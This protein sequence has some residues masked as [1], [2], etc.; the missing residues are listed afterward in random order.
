MSGRTP[1]SAARGR[2]EQAQGRGPGLAM[3]VNGASPPLPR[4]A[5]F[6]F[7]AVLVLWLAAVAWY[8]H[9]Q[10]PVSQNGGLGWDGAK[11]EHMYRQAQA[12]ERL[13]EEKPYVFRVATPWLAAHLGMHEARTAFHIVNLVSVLITGCLMLWIMAALGAR[14]G[15][16]LFL[17]GT[18]F[19]Q[20]HAPL[21]QQFY[22]SFGVDAASQPFTCLIFLAHIAIRNRGRRLAALSLAAFAG[23]FF[24]ESVIFA[25]GAVW[26]AELAA[27][28]AEAGDL[29][30]ARGQGG[31]GDRDGFP[32]RLIGVLARERSLWAAAIPMGAGL[33][34][35]AITHLLA[36]GSGPYSFLVTILYY[37]YHKPMMVLVHAFYNGYGTALIPVLVFRRRAW[38]FIKE[39]PILAVYPLI[40]FA[41]GWTAGGDTTRINYWGCLALLPL[42]ALVLSDLKLAT[43]GIGGFLLLEAVT[44]RMFFPIPDY[45][46]SEAWRFPILTGWGSDLPVFDLWSELANPRVLMISLFQ[47]LALTAIAFFWIHRVGAGKYLRDGAGR[48]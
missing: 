7:A 18:F 26:L 15:V 19:L 24:R 38:A 45:P 46:G 40:T 39:R 12:G 11:Y 41:L 31:S 35:I 8:G 30:A 9:A 13:A 20:W 6:H 16:S 43:F 5:W 22:D 23:V 4:P 21:R 10:K 3:P 14:P 36:D 44:T 33:A 2:K 25:A 48:A 42:M 1:A 28:M 32:T 47:Y 34:G 27:A 37:L 29:G 17:I